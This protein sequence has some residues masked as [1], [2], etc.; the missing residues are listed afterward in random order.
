MVHGRPEGFHGTQKGLIL[1]SK[2]PEFE[3]ILK[4]E[5]EVRGLV[6]E[7]VTDCIPTLYNTV[8][9]RAYGND[10]TI[11]LRSADYAVNQFAAL[12]VFLKLQST[13]LGALEWREEAEGD[14]QGGITL[15]NTEEA[16]MKENLPDFKS[17]A[18]CYR[19]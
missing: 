5:V 3:A 10:S 19:P 12:V 17:Y 13:W 2:Q 15:E 1:L 8:L 18:A 4:S 11:T 9:R 14:I 6:L 7:E 16:L